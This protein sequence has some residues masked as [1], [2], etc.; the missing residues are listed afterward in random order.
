MRR[1]CTVHYE[2]TVRVRCVGPW[3]LST[4]RRRRAQTRRPGRGGIQNQHSTTVDSTHRVHASVCAFTLKV[5]DARSRLEYLFSMTLLPGSPPSG[6][7]RGGRRWAVAVVGRGVGAGVGE[8]G[9]GGR[10]GRCG[11]GRTGGTAAAAA[12]RGVG[13]RSA[14]TFDIETKVGGG[15]AGRFGSAVELVGITVYGGKEY[16]VRATASAASWAE[17]RERLRHAVESFRIEAQ[18]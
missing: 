10:W 12:A 17:E 3:A 4:S 15:T 8:S 13:G 16:L 14:L 11:R 1:A 18:C 6:S 9:R 7:A 5:S 2:Q